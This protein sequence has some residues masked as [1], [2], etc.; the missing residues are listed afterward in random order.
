MTQGHI[1]AHDPGAEVSVAADSSPCLYLGVTLE[2]PLPLFLSFSLHTPVCPSVSN[3]LLSAPAVLG[4]CPFAHSWAAPRDENGVAL[5]L[6][7]LSF[8]HLCYSHG[9]VSDLHSHT[10]TQKR[11][12]ARVESSVGILSPE[13][14]RSREGEKGGRRGGRSPPAAQAQASALFNAL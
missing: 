8:T 3:P 13:K 9:R 2:C 7:F 1:L 12:E 5:F 11:D 10:G 6:V 4:L 14:G